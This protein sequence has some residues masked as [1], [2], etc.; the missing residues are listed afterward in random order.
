[1][2]TKSLAL[3]SAALSRLLFQPPG[4]HCI[5][6]RHQD[7]KLPPR[8]KIKSHL[9]FCDPP[10]EQPKQIEEMLI[11]WYNSVVTELLLYIFV[12]EDRKATLT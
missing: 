1:M 3:F 7:R 8:E 12:A 4:A 6:R 5:S 2:P 10:V 9:L 11:Y